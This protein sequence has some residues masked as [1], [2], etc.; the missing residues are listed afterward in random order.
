MPYPIFA[1]AILAITS[2]SGDD[3]GVVNRDSGGQV[4][5]RNR[6]DVGGS[7]AAHGDSTPQANDSGFAAERDSGQQTDSGEFSSDAAHGQADAGPAANDAGEAQIQDGGAAP[8]L[9]VAAGHRLSSRILRCDGEQ[10]SHTALTWTQGRLTGLTLREFGELSINW[11]VNWA[12]GK[13]ESA[14]GRDADG[15]LHQVRWTYVGDRLSR[16]TL[17]APFM[18]L[19]WSYRYDEQGRLVHARFG[20][21]FDGEEFVQQGSFG[22]GDE[23]PTLF[24]GLPINYAG[25]RPTSIAGEPIRYQ[26]ERLVALPGG[27]A[28]YAAGGLIN[29]FDEGEGCAYVY[30]FEAGVR[31]E[32]FQDSM[33]FSGLGSL[34]GNNGRFHG[35]LDPGRWIYL[36]LSLLVGE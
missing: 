13:P 17:N 16:A 3:E 24:L 31:A 12:Q 28:E 15:A 19:N 34:Y 26:G 1:L 20:E 33:P 2:C 7:D 14:R 9:S 18:Q 10:I 30:G 21:T 25:G 32:Y 29:R 36:L 8:E 5:S 4:D 11:T 6:L 35:Q 22:Y 23:G 27:S